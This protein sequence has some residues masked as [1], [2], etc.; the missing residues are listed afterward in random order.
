MSKLKQN[1]FL[2]TISYLRQEEHLVIHDNIMKTKQ[3]EDDDVTLFLKQEYE[4]ES[5][6]YPLKSPIFDEN[7]GLWAAKIVYYAAQLLLN[8]G[9]TRKD[10]D[11]FFFNLIGDIT[12]S[13]ILSVDLCLRFLP[14]INLQLKSI[15]ADDPL[16]NI[17]DNLLEIWQYSAIDNDSKPP[18]N[19]LL[20]S[21]NNPCISQLYLD[22]IIEKQVL[23]WAELPD[24]NPLLN[25]HL[26]YHKDTFWKTL[27]TIETEI[28]E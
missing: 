11:L 28:N 27:K 5:L 6:N 21:I 18:E 23:L 17:L 4:N 25:Q 9:N 14:Q 22:R 19:S 3:S 12:P 15:D 8:R 26:G 16:V 20:L 1:N 10:L 13:K 24:I 7:A 2:E